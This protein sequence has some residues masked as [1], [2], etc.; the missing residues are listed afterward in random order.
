MKIAFNKKIVK[1]PWGG[2]NQMLSMLCNYLK[3]KGHK[4]SFDLK[5]SPDI[6]VIMDVKDRSC[7]FSIEQLDNFKKKNKITVV[8]R[9]NDNGSHRKNNAERNNDRMIYVNNKLADKTI[10]ISNWLKKYYQERGLEPKNS[11]VI[12]NGTDR[13]TFYPDDRI[14]RHNEPIKL[15]T[16]HWSSNMAKGY[17]IY[18]KISTFCNNNPEIATFKFLGNCPENM[19]NNCCKI[20]PKPFK[21][22]PQYLNGQDC[23]ITATQFE[24]GGCHIVEGMACGLIPLVCIGGGGTEDYSTG[25][26]FYYK[27][28]DELINIIKR[29][30]NNYDTYNNY[31]NYLRINYTYGSKEMNEFYEKVII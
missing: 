16:H 24:S 28:I 25:Y 31:R 11:Y 21:E 27:T 12:Q 26:G 7:S 14:R 19:L 10:F 5:D 3:E 18:D 2:G 20:S 30:R 22:I 4:I 17:V 29:L 6:V 8:H 1:G 9:I 23:Y 13:N 15:V